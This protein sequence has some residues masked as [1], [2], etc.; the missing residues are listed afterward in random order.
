M[1][2]TQHTGGSKLSVTAA[3]PDHESVP[4]HSRV[5]TEDSLESMLAALR[6]RIA[7]LETDVRNL[8]S[9]TANRA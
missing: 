2:D 4:G 8:Q 5:G 7:R 6:E 9:R 1:R 3:T